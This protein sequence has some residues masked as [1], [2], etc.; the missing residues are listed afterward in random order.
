MATVNGLPFFDTMPDFASPPEPSVSL[1][2]HLADHGIG[3]KIAGFV[4]RREQQI[5]TSEFKTH[6]AAERHAVEKFFNE[7]KGSGGGFYVPSWHRDVDCPSG[8]TSGIDTL[9]ISPIDYDTVYLANTDTNAPGKWLFAYSAGGVMQTRNVLSYT[10]GA[11]TV[12]S[13]WTTAV[14]ADELLC[15]FIHYVRFLDDTL[16]VEY[17]GQEKATISVQMIEVID[18]IS[19]ADA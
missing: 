8:I 6:S 18:V 17:D 12:D 3:Q 16:R 1:K 9:E 5:L 7:R 4:G 2:M 13:E 19:D 15:G 11:L 10:T 14:V